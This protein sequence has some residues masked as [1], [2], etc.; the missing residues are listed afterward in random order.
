MERVYCRRGYN[1]E[2][3]PTSRFC[4]VGKAMAA[5][6]EAGPG[7][8]TGYYAVDKACDVFCALHIA[9]HPIQRI[10]QAAQHDSTHVS[11]LPPPCDEFTTRE[12]LFRA[13]RVRPPG[14]TNISFP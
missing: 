8:R 5:S 11:L 12:P 3:K 6:T 14:K 10:G 7:I 4:M 1:D 9:A 2:P 13:T